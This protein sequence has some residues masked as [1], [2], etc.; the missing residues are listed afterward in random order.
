[1]LINQVKMEFKIKQ[2]G[3]HADK[4]SENGV[5]DETGKNPKQKSKKT[6]TK[7]KQKQ[8]KTGSHAD[9]AS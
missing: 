2:E 7:T 8:K 4:P 3:G 1:M 9:K 5:Q 6:K